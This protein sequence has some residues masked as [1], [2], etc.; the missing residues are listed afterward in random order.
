[1]ELVARV[2]PDRVD[3][4]P[5]RALALWTNVHG[6]ASLAANRTLEV[7]ADGQDPLE[8]VAGIVSAH[9]GDWE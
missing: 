8:L 5:R 1:M 4:A 2:D 3:S 7:V 9:L 6:L